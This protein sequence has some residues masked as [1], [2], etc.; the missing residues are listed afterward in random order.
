MVHRSTSWSW[1]DWKCTIR[2]GN[3]H[4][5]VFNFKYGVSDWIISEQVFS[6]SSFNASIIFL[7][8]SIKALGEFDRIDPVFTPRSTTISNSQIMVLCHSWNGKTWI[9]L[10]RSNQFLWTLVFV[11]TIISSYQPLWYQNPTFFWE[12]KFLAAFYSNCGKCTRTYI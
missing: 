7:S 5:R 6:S 12:W 10:H 4:F 1:Q 11:Y 3:Y 8:S 9:H 2:N